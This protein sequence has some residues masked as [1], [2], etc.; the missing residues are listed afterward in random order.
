M[1]RAASEQINLHS[2]VLENT[3]AIAANGQQ[4]QVGKIL[5]M[6]Q[7]VPGRLHAVLGRQP[8]AF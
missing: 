8:G 1:S 3:R 7:E 4:G 2:L 6:R 5:E